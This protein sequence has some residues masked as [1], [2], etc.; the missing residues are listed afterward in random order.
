M[1][2][3][4]LFQLVP[5]GSNLQD[6]GF[7]ELNLGYLSPQISNQSGKVRPRYSPS[8]CQCLRLDSNRPH[9]AINTILSQRRRA[10]DEAT[11]E[12]ILNNVVGGPGGHGDLSPQIS[13][14]SDKVRPRYSPSKFQYLRMDSNRPHYAFNTMLSQRRRAS[15]GATDGATGETILNNVVGGPGWHGDEPLRVNLH[16]IANITFVLMHLIIT[17]GEII[18]LLITVNHRTRQILNS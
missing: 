10:S 18:D 3:E 8:K 16:K 17:H 12:A 9:Y 5:D 1:I 7:A 6:E 13:T 11:G 14:Q 15:D 4:R 2:G